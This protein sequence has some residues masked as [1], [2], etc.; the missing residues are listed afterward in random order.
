MIDALRARFPAS[1][2]PTPRTFCLSRVRR[3]RQRAARELA[4]RVDVVLVVGRRP[5]APTPTACARSPTEQRRAQPISSPTPMALDP[6]ARGR[7]LGRTSPAALR[8]QPSWCRELI[9]RLEPLGGC[10][11]LGRAPGHYRERASLP[12]A[13]AELG[14][15]PVRPHFR[16]RF[17]PEP[18]PF[19]PRLLAVPINQMDPRRPYVATSASRASSALS[20]RPHAGAI[21]PLPFSACAAAARSSYCDAI[22]RPR[23][24]SP[25][26]LEAVDEC[27]APVVLD[28]RQRAA[29]APRDRGDG[30][31]IHRAQVRLSLHQRAADRK[32]L[33]PF[34]ARPLF[35]WSV[36]LDGDREMSRTTTRCAR[37]AFDRVV[38]RSRLPRATVSA[39]T[40]DCRRSS[41]GAEPH[42]VAELLRQVM[43]MA[44]TASPY[45]PAMPT[46]VRRSG[47]L[48]QPRKT[49]LFRAIFTR[50]RRHWSFGRP[51]S[52]RFLA[53]DQ[54]YPARPRATRR[55]PISAGSA[56]LLLGEGYAKTNE[57]MTTEWDLG[58]GN[59][60]MRRNTWCTAR[61]EATSRHRWMNAM[62]GAGHGIEGMRTNGAWARNPLDDGVAGTSHRAVSRRWTASTADRPRGGLAA[63]ASSAPP[64]PISTSNIS[65]INQAT[66]WAGPGSPC[67]SSDPRVC[68]RRRRRGSTVALLGLIETSR[69]HGRRYSG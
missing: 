27:G 67:V 13:P 47:A 3:N 52:P 36:H 57:L 37:K 44:S 58:T 49:K 5:T 9:D 55:A 17:W 60:E 4:L 61:Y 1:S 31:G 66:R 24:P 30:R 38:G 29:L 25:D 62:K 40:S 20:A 51:A 35:V 21:L 56:L 50:Q 42:R 64:V 10:S 12:R 18:R 65:I 19:P 22:L 6:V 59:Y 14:S 68:R 41:N 33:R 32:A 2:G 26:C 16:L 11:E 39:S 53:G 45:R 63:T 54:N 15:T 7:R 43:A 23:L 34:R 46:G 8:R 28:R 48:P 69:Q